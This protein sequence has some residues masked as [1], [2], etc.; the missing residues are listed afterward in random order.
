MKNWNPRKKPCHPPF[1]KDTHILC[2]LQNKERIKYQ[3]Q[4]KKIKTNQNQLNNKFSIIFIYS[5]VSFFPRH[6]EL[7]FFPPQLPTAVTDNSLILAFSDEIF[8][9]VKYSV[10][11]TTLQRTL[12]TL[13]IQNIWK[14]FCS[15]NTLKIKNIYR[16]KLFKNLTIS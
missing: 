2:Y 9:K 10:Y 15:L 4:K 11:T 7:K 12:S 6:L 13:K 14:D 16:R 5:R 1:R 3:K 8:N